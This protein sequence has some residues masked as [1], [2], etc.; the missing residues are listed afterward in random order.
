MHEWALAEAVLESVRAE[1]RSRSGQ[2]ASSVTIRFGELQSIDPDVFSEGVNQLAR[3]DRELDVA[4]QFEGEPATFICAACGRGWSLDDCDLDE[5][6]REAIH[7]L[8]EV[9]HSFVACPDCGSADFRVDRGRGVTIE[10]I[11]FEPADRDGEQ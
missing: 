9:V 6:T 8:P 5:A 1:Q 11:E 4:F 2:R 10:S 7:F 3:D